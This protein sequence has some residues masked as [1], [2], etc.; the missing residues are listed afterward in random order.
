MRVA[1]KKT[2]GAGAT[3]YR[4]QAQEPSKHQKGSTQSRVACGSVV[5]L[6]RAECDA[7]R[8]AARERGL[9]ATWVR[10]GDGSVRWLLRGQRAGDIRQVGTVDQLRRVLGLMLADAEPVRDAQ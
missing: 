4:A 8:A 5:E 6:T 2:P 7:V 9:V 1:A 3:A 10:H